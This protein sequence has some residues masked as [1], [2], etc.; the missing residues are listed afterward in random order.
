MLSNLHISNFR[1]FKPLKIDKLGKINI[2][3]GRNNSG[4][5]SLLEAIFLL[6]GA[7]NPSLL[8]N[9]NVIRGVTVISGSEQVVQSALWKPIFHELDMNKAI[10]VTGHHFSCG[11]V[12]VRLT[13]ERPNLFELPLDN[14]KVSIGD[15]TQN[16]ETFI[17][18]YVLNGQPKANFNITLTGNAMQVQADQ[19][20][21]QI[22]FLAAILSARNRNSEEDAQRMGHLRQQK[23]GD[24]VV[25][26]LRVIEPRLQSLEVNTA[27]G[28]AMIWGDVGLSELVPLPVMGDGMIQLARIVLAI[29]SAPDGVVLIDEI[30]NGLHHSVLSEVWQVIEKAANQFNTQIIA[31]THSY[32]CIAAAEQVFK[33]A[34]DDLFLLHRI[35]RLK[36]GVKCVTYDKE[37]MGTAIEHNMEVR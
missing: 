26:A 19:T 12:A 10:E 37:T 9:A 30:E 35:E 27:T 29:S 33:S 32:E 6:S 22:P 21:V 14:G 31:T 15:K 5:T 7:A 36:T 28:G 8:L 34:D 25:D 2:V 13:L 4:K 24:L 17:L 3:S 23:K 11:E 20:D 1:A 16:K 18:S